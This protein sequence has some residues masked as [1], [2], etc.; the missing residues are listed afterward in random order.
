M[1]SPLPTP[2]GNLYEAPGTLFETE[3][4]VV[5]TADPTVGNTFNLTQDL[6]KLVTSNTWKTTFTVRDLVTYQL[7]APIVTLTKAVTTINGAGAPESSGDTVHGGDSVGYT[8]TVKD[9]G[10]VDAYDVEVWDVL[11]VQDDC[12][13]VSAIVPASGA[14]VTGTGG[15]IIEWPPSAIP[16]LAAGASTTL[17][18]AMTVPTT[19][20]AG[21]TFSNTAGVRSFVGEHNDSG[22]PDNL[23]YPQSNIDSSVTTGEENASV[24][25]QTVDVVSA[26]ATVTKTAITSITTAGNTN[27]DATIGETITY[28][29]DVTVPHDTTFYTASLADPLGT[30]QTYVTGSGVVT[31]PDETTFTEAAGG[32]EGFAYAYNAGSNTV[33]L[34]FP[35][36]YPN[37]TSTDEVVKVVFSTLVAN[38]AGN[39]RNDNVTNVATLTDH[40]ST[41]GVITASNTPLNT[42]VVEPDVTIAKTVSPAKIQPGGTNTFTITVTNKNPTGV[43]SA[44]DL[45]G[46]DTI[47]AALSYVAGSVALG[48]PVAGTASESA[49]VVT[50]SIPGPLNANQADT[51]TYQVNPPASNQMTNG[52]TFPNT[53]TLTSWQ[54]VNGGGPGTRSY[55]PASSTVTLAAEFPNLVVTKSTPDGNQALAGQPFLW[56]VSVKN[57]TTVAIANSL[58]VTDTLPASWTYDTGTTTV[59]PPTGP[60]TQPEPT[61]TVNG[62]GD[63]LSWTGLGTLNPGQTLTIVYE[64]TPALALQTVA[65]TGPSYPYPNSAYATATDNTGSSG[66]GSVSQYTS[67]TSTV[68]AYIGDA[69]LQITKTHSGNFS[70]GADG[71]YSLVVRNNGPSTAAPAVT[72]T[73]P[74]VSPETYVSA[75]GSNSSYKWGCTYSSGTLTVTCTLET[76]GGSA[77]TLPSGTV[78]PTLSV[79][80]DTLSSTPDGTEVTNTATVISPTWDNNTANNTSSDPTTIDANADLA[81][82]KSHTGNFTAGQQGIYTISIQNHGPSDAVGPLSVIDTLPSSE[83]LV[84]A[85]GTGWACGAVLAGQFTCTTAS[86]L[87]SGSF[88][89]PITELVAV[90]A[91]QLPGS[92]TNTASVGSPTNDPVPGNNTSSNPTTI[93]TLADLALTKVHEGTFVAGDDATYDFTVTNSEGP[94]DAAGPLKVTDPLPSGETFVRDGGGSTGWACSAAAGTVTCTD[95]SG[96][97]VGG[98]TTFTVTVAVASGVTVATLINSATLSSPTTDP[99]PANETSTDNAGTT[100]SADLQVVKSLTS[101]LVAG[102]SAIYSLAVTD[103]GPSDAAGPVS[104]TDTLP[105]GE[106]YVGATGT[107]WSCSASSGTVTC[108]HATAITGGSETAVT[109]TVLLTSDVLPQSITNTATV[110]SSTPDP[111]AG[112]NTDSTT[113]TSTSRADLGITK[114]DSGPFTAG[115]HGEY[116]ITVSNVGPSDAQEP[117]VTDTLPS[118]ETYVGAAGA[119]WVC[120]AD[121]QVVTCT[122]G[123]NLVAGISAPTI[124]LMVTISPS[125]ESASVTNTASVSSSTSDSN[126][127]NDSASDTTGIDTSADLAITKT[128]T[129][130]FTAGSDG[131]YSLTVTN[132]GP[133]DALAPTV[134]DQVP[135]PFSVVSASGGSAWDCSGSSANHVS[136]TALASLPAGDTASTLW[137][138]VSTPPSQAATTVTNT[139]SVLS[140]TSDPV[141]SNNSSSDPTSIVTS[142][143]LWVTKTHQGTFT[144]GNDGSYVIAVGNL[145]PS[146]AAEP[147][148]VSDTLPASETFASATG[149]GWSCSDDLQVVT[150][151]DAANLPSGEDAPDIDLSVLV[152]S[153]ATGS[154]TNTAT[155]ASTTSD[156]VTANNSG[157]DTAALALSSDLSITKTHTGDFTA[158]MDGT[159]IIGVHNAGP[160]DSGTGVV[161][162]D[163]LPSGETFVSAEGTGWSCTAV[164]VTVTCTLGT[165]VVVAGDAPS[166]T[167]T[168]AVRSGAVGILTNVAV[169][170]GPNP[171][172]VLGNNTASDPTISDRV[173]DLSLTKTLTGSLQDRVDATYVFVVTNTGPSDSAA[174]VTLTDPLPAGLTLVS[175]TAGTA[176]AWSCAAA[177][178]TVTCTDSA[179]VVT[180]T[181]STFDIRVAVSAAAGSE[182]TNTATVEAAGDVGAASEF[183]SADGGVAAAAPIPDAGASGGQAPWPLGALLLV[184]GGLGM[185]AGS[186]RRHW[187]LPRRGRAG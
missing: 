139:A 174:P 114:S 26:G 162:S 41:G 126:P 85:T 47:P 51:I 113:N 165:S 145:G 74:I 96:L 13:D 144:A 6:A 118:G 76:P 12:A 63:V 151:A 99:V 53:A 169:V 62:S 16:D 4:S 35:T 59:T 172:P 97:N 101:P 17:T 167:L 182:I 77:T 32:S 22:Q 90:A 68:D 155:V 140:A 9:T 160:S 158:G 28:T 45:V 66:N 14:C 129:G 173:S 147:V 69:D 108:T 1:G 78:A 181:T 157:S 67:N 125:L 5:A 89:Q 49:G 48:G 127:G 44:F 123:T 71:T 7:A 180:G 111:D 156:P 79:V 33:N 130:A 106:T 43:S 37:M 186:R 179:P 138:V 34:T 42:L 19:A 121:E 75:S 72:V 100:Q 10:L 112:N 38:V 107:D 170:L 60:A 70:A 185:V 54:G 105:A 91:A 148:V 104:L 29:V 183:A 57:N 83:S 159:Y 166:L 175:S 133:S 187:H 163:T 134:T 102:D 50:W 184:I 24:A 27:P 15:E 164:D 8:V 18:Y 52:E 20:G 56:E 23:Y 93:V 168:V 21:E 55:G 81:I 98:T 25:D 109:L 95:A 117:V 152:A 124:D 36:P 153:A 149:T 31:L 120:S 46:T 2:D 116:H 115:D 141:E 110:S 150:C 146:D 84:S 135:S 94:S 122:D 11:P 178:Q 161:V 128:H 132:N 177:G 137:V 88:A 103:N 39:Q 142:A 86:G 82:T 87:T 65:T 30:L 40:S 136:C 119:G 176:G 80:V 3:F 92:I 143:D 73:D 58:A 131:T 61:V 154:V 171:D 64:A